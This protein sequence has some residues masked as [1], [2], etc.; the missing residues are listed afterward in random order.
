MAERVLIVD[1]EANMRWVL[2]EALSAAG[3][4]VAVAASGQ[5]A[6]HEMGRHLVDLVLLDLKLK[7]MDG[8]ATLRRLMERWPEAVVIILTA[9]GTVATAVEAMQLGAAD[10]LRKPFDVEEIGFKIQRALERNALQS[11]VRR[12][13]ATVQQTVGEPVGADVA[14]Q[15][16][17]EQV[18]SLT[19]LELDIVLVGEAGSGRTTLARF[20][21]GTRARGMAP[22]VELDLQVVPSEVQQLVLLGGDRGEGLWT[23]A[24]S[25]TLLLRNRERL[26]DAAADALFR[27]VAQR[28]A[29]GP[30][31][32][33]TS[34]TPIAGDRVLP[35]GQ[36]HVPPLRE[37]PAD[38]PLLVRVLLPSADVTPGVIAALER[39]VWPG[40]IAELRGM[41]ERA[42]V[43][44]AG[45]A[46]E[47]R[48]LPEHIRQVSVPGTLIQLPRE[49][50]N[51]EAVEITLLRQA[52]EQAH[53][54][55]SRAADLLGLTRHTLL[56][57]LEKYGLGATSNQRDDHAEKGS[58]HP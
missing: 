54:N 22:L 10:Y 14:W 47:E 40:N 58:E 13:R 42:S 44:A 23:K 33:L 4:D 2:K 27:L 29:G 30:R 24:G 21:H 52:L 37:H 17:V 50:L 34:E 49:G 3:Y 5:E 35:M 18:R 12:L 26:A 43:L 57:R 7:G 55:K 51:L 16:C 28:G 32:I 11:E 1:D 15:R 36:V 48:H 9:H 19:A 46:I 25:G 6:L 56:Y 41:L 45:G 38:L 53:G 20:A 39:Y 31:L 8:L